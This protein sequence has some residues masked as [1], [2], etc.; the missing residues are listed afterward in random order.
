MKPNSDDEREFQLA[1]RLIQSR[2]VYKR[3][4]NGINNIVGKILSRHGVAA[5]QSNSEIQNAWLKI[6]GNEWGRVTQAGVV[7]RG[8]LEV[9]VANSLINQQLG[10]EK[11][12]L[13][14][15][16]KKELPNINIKDLV[17]RVGE[18]RR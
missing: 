7:K 17:F 1:N 3:R 11:Q 9:I 15:G 8:K 2:Q 13:L 10:F 4:P 5:E 16:L 12:K 6:A 14:D 18:I